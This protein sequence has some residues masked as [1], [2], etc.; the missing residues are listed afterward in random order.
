MNGELLL[1]VEHGYPLRLVVPSWY[2][3]ASVK[4]LT[5]IEVIGSP[6]EGFFQTERYVYET[7]PN[8]ST[9]REPVRLQNVRSVITEPSTGQDV[10]TGDLVIRGV[11]WSG[12]APA[13]VFRLG[14]PPGRGGRVGGPA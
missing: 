1:P 13:P 9:V 4:W 6:F 3:V 14:L 10:T 2:A 12:A 8:G 5:E 11:A 7:Q